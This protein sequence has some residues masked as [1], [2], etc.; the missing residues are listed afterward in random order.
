VHVLGCTHTV[1][2]V[3]LV[4]LQSVE[5]IARSFALFN[6]FTSISLLAG[7]PFMGMSLFLASLWYLLNIFVLDLDDLDVSL[8]SSKKFT[9]WGKVTLRYILASYELFVILDDVLR[10]GGDWL[11]DE[12]VGF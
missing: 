7:S 8:E 9:D 1:E 5:Q 3:V 4:D 10:R 11:K 2:N 12:P 6:L